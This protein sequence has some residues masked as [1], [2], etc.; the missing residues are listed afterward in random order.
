MSI[1]Q[2]TTQQIQDDLRAIDL[3]WPGGVPREQADRVNALSR[4]L[5]RRTE[6][7]DVPAPSTSRVA[8]NNV[9]D[10]PQEDLERELRTL[11]ERVARNSND[12]AAQARFAD[13]R[14]ELQRRMKAAPPSVSSA[15]EYD[16]TTTAPV[17]PRSLELPS[18][19][20]LDRRTRESSI[21]G[22]LS[23][24][25]T[26]DLP[27]YREVIDKGSPVGKVAYDGYGG[28]KGSATET[29]EG[30]SSPKKAGR[31]SA[32]TS[33]VASFGADKARPITVVFRVGSST[34]A[35]LN[36]TTDEARTLAAGLEYCVQRVDDG[37]A[38]V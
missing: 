30:S 20:E 13:V 8:Y 32:S 23:L 29:A 33:V 2:M 4:E 25:K 38:N 35:Q 9:A 19:E 37:D 10:V 1:K 21:R 34:L 22:S 16:A 11:A 36:L 31:S 15:K 12:E 17:A 3:T 5:R 24:P 18:D 6:S 7:G 28:H 26:S 27:S 14:F